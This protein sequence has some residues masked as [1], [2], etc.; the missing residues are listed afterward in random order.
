VFP[1]GTPGWKS[2]GNTGIGPLVR[3]GAL[4]KD[5]A[6]YPTAGCNTH[7]GDRHARQGSIINR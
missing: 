3:V 6:F 5:A 1:V 2:P 7:R 4:V